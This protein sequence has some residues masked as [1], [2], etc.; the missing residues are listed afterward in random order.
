MV[1]PKNKLLQ[2]TYKKAFDYISDRIVKEPRL[3]AHCP[4]VLGAINSFRR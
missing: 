1:S 4:G 2:D 3:P